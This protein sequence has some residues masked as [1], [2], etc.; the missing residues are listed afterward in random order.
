MRRIQ[1]QSQTFHL[2]A[3]PMNSKANQFLAQP[4]FIVFARFALQPARSLNPLLSQV[5]SVLPTEAVEFHKRIMVADE[6]VRSQHVIAVNY[7]QSAS[8]SFEFSAVALSKAH[9][10]WI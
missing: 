8:S 2:N 7:I 10:S 4:T 3:D 6:Q 1:L 9:E 5:S